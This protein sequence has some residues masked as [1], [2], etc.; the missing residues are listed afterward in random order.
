MSR[1]QSI[2]SRHEKDAKS[3]QKAS[4]WICR[5]ISV[6]KQVMTLLSWM[7]KW[8]SVISSLCR[9]RWAREPWRFTLRDANKGVEANESL[10]RDVLCQ[11]VNCPVQ[12]HLANELTSQCDT[13]F[14]TRMNHDHDRVKSSQNL[15][16]S[17]FFLQF[18]FTEWVWIIPWPPKTC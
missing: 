13:I 10:C 6:F 11:S 1:T 15:H 17:N 8:I 9:C 4:V 18:T 7:S 14:T 12:I 16:G 5:K 3:A 2:A